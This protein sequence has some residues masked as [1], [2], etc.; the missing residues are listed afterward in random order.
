M[1]TATIICLIMSW[2]QLFTLP[3]AAATV[4]CQH[5]DINQDGIV[6][7]SDFSLLAIDF[8]SSQPQVVRTDINQDGIVDLTDFSW[9]NINFLLTCDQ[10]FSVKELRVM[11]IGF[12]PAFGD[13]SLVDTYFTS[14]QLNSASQIEQLT[15]QRT[16]SD[17]HTITHQQ[18]AVNLVKHLD[19]STN[20]TYADGFTFDLESYSQCVWGHPNYNPSFCEA[21]KFQFDYQQW[22][23]DHQICTH[24]NQADIDE[25]WMLSPPYILAWENFMIGPSHGFPVNGPSLVMPEC[26]KH[27]IVVNG[28]YDR[29][30]NMMHNVAH[31]IEQTMNFVSAYW[32]QSD[33]EKYWGNFSGVSLYY[34]QRPAQAYCGNGHFPSNTTVAYDYQNLTLKENTCAD[35]N[36]LPNFTS[37]T[38]TINC[39]AWGCN[40]RSWQVYWLSHLP[41]KSGSTL[42]E[43]TNQ[44]LFELPHNWWPFLLSPT[45]AIELRASTE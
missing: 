6:D 8:L 19:I 35:W 44:R 15:W 18:Y 7:L 17:F 20:Y 31:R 10:D 11:T 23:A 30:E 24:A 3:T 32:N 12:N 42:L 27:I 41:H 36:N 9:L 26:N 34:N 4:D 45:K 25:I 29:P 43:S 1:K 5:T 33:K 13:T 39:Q 21:R 22:L 38:Q 2:L 40:D 37:E 14:N 16:Q 28:V